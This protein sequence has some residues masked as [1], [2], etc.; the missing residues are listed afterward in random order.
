MSCA[1]CAGRHVY[2][3]GSREMVV[4]FVRD[5]GRPVAPA[6]IAAHFVMTKDG[7][8]QLLLDARRRGEL[9]TRQRGEWVPARRR[10]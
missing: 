6:E 3:R 2:T 9:T 10:A 8:N 5:A 7:V 1:R 4:A